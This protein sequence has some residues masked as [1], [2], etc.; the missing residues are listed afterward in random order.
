MFDKHST[1]YADNVIY[2]INDNVSLL[3]YTSS[4][5]SI[6]MYE[7]DGVRIEVYLDANGQ[8][9]FYYVY[10]DGTREEIPIIEDFFSFPFL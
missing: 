4:E 1:T 6:L 8:R 7:V 2:N 3:D 5:E 9:D 10:A